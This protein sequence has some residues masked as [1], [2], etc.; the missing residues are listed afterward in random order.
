MGW[1]FG[2]VEEFFQI[3]LMGL[4]LEAKIKH[5][6]SGEKNVGRIEILH[7]TLLPKNFL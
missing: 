5:T 3:T 2:A 6:S 7:F 1:G 4:R